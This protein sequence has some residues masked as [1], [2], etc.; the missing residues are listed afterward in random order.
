[1]ENKRQQRN[2][3]SRRLYVLPANARFDSS[4]RSNVN[5]ISRAGSS[6]RGFE[7]RSRSTVKFR[8]RLPFFVPRLVSLDFCQPNANFTEEF[9]PAFG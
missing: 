5:L 4:V 1:M 3:V 6:V 7:K 9:H 8:E 2:P